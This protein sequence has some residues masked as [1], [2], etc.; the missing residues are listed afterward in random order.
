MYGSTSSITSKDYLDEL[1]TSLG[2]PIE[3]LSTSMA[4][5]YFRSSGI[6]LSANTTYYAIFEF[7]SSVSIKTSIR[8][9]GGSNLPKDR[10]YSTDLSSWSDWSCGGNICYAGDNALF[11][12]AE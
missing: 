3:N 12:L 1:S 2:E 5:A 11:F 10:K 8:G 9:T 7:S 4:Q 6:N